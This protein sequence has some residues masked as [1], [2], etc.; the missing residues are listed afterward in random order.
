MVTAGVTIMEGCD[1]FCSYCIVPYTRGKEI[2]RPVADIIQEVDQLLTQ[3][4]KEITL[5]GQNV[6]HY[7]G[8]APDGSIV[9]LAF[10][11]HTISQFPGI[12]RIRFSTSHPEFFDQDLI[13]CYAEVDKLANH[14]HLPVQSGS[15]TI[16]LAM[17]RLYKIETFIEK[18]Q[19]IRAI[20]E[21][22]TISSDFIVGFPNETDDEFNETL[23]LVTK[24]NIDQS[25][26][27][28]YSPRP[29]TPAATIQCN[30][31]EQTK[32]DRLKIL[33][34]QLK[35]NTKSI[36]ET[37][38]D[39]CFKILVTGESNYGNTLT[40]RTESNRIVHFQ[41]HNSLIGNMANVKITEVLS[42]CLRGR[43]TEY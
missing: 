10:L 23:E 32:K 29:G 25:F 35:N 9:N 21:D 39:K 4:V 40:G 1:E 37:M 28:I 19:A 11:I 3:G 12:E 7:Q 31:S 16:L 33:Q 22:I 15:N 5:L 26:S 27:F 43:I 17:K 42:N 20:R 41:G 30:L 13:D 38:I 36:N 14:L 2:N 34:N 18:I 6:N 8:K 24:Y